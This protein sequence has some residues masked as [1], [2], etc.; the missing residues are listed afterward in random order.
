MNNRQ[1]KLYCCICEIESMFLNSKLLT[2]T[3]IKNLCN[4]L[5]SYLNRTKEEGIDEEYNTLSYIYN[6]LQSILDNLN[7]KGTPKMSLLKK[8]HLEIKNKSPKS[9]S[10]IPKNDLKVY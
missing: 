3:R 2:K 6:E 5:C 8:L 4:N 1:Y 7:I 9:I 10:P